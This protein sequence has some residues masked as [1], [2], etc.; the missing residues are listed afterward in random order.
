MKKLVTTIIIF[1][2]L[3]VGI[4]GT[5]YF[6]L[7]GRK[8]TPQQ[9]AQAAQ[10]KVTIIEGW[11]L[12]NIADDLNANSKRAGQAHLATQKEF[13]DSEKS[14]PIEN[15]PLLKSKP[16][17]ADLQG[18]LFPDTYFLPIQ[19]GSSTTESAILIKK[20]LDNFSQKFTLKMEEDAKAR[21]MSVYQIITLAS[22]IEKETG[23]NVVT[24]EQ[25]Q[26]LDIQ[27]K[28][29]SG[30]FYNR[31]A[32]NMPLQS[33]ATVNFITKKNTP[34]ATRE[35][36]KINS[37]YNTYVYNGLPPGPI[38]NPSLS[39]I[40]SAL[41][42]TKTNYFYFL[43]I[44]PSGEAVYSTTYDEQLQNKQKYLR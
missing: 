5:I 42:P 7:K 40:M 26:A 19:A 36:T 28:I 34:S 44:Q 16:G 41:Y 31:L 15:Y 25:R 20:A 3:T 37:P 9:P 33:D 32:I 6:K 10:T 43:H 23:R 8:N 21:G 39:S 14:F 17:S 4:A 2:V 35:D 38:C 27:R 30:I 13:F 1:V 18:F 22:I 29:I 12:D 24:N 11:T